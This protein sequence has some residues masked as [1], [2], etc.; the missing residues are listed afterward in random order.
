MKAQLFC[1]VI[2]AFQC[3][4]LSSGALRIMRKTKCL[5]SSIVMAMD[6]A[7]P[8]LSHP[9]HARHDKNTSKG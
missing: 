5:E 8:F 4:Y 3:S 9:L 2:H 1:Q 7:S 6:S